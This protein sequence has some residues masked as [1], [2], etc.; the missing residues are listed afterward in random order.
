MASLKRDP[1]GLPRPE[2][3]DW[4]LHGHVGNDDRGGTYDPFVEFD[5]APDLRALWLRHR[6]ALLAEWRKRGGSGPC[7]AARQ[8]ER[9]EAACRRAR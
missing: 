2:I 6:R 5:P 1:T 4:L 9:P 7:W 8:F 3:V